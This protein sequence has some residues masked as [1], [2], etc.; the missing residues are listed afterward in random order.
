M[1]PAGRPKGPPRTRKHYALEDRQ[2][3]ELDALRQV[4]PFGRPP[5]VETVRRAIDFYIEEQKRRMPTDM[6]A[7][8]DR[9]L[10]A[11]RPRIV[12]LPTGQTE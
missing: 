3:A 1:A 7:E 9:I 4:S 2:I 8:Y 5:F 10:G 6:R 11:R 12:R